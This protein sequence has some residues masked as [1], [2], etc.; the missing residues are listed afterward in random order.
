MTLQQPQLLHISLDVKDVVYTPNRE[1]Y[2][3]INYFKPSGRILEPCRG[4]GAFTQYLPDA[5]WCDIEQGRDFFAWN[6]PVDWCFGNPPYGQFSK[7]MYHS[8][9]ISEN[10]CYLIPL[11]KPFISGK[12]IIKML[13]WG[14]AKHMRFYGTGHELKF[15]TGF[16]VGAVYF[17]RDYFGGMT[18]SDG[19]ARV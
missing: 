13:E 12:M 5:E 18:M 9:T 1:A 10:I 6:E 3:M 14:G 16:A 17:Q 4:L 2:D 11:D 19:R 8:M 7:W 15:P